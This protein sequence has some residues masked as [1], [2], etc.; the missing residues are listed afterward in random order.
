MGR[1]VGQILAHLYLWD[2]DCSLDQ[3]GEDL[4]LSKAAVSVAARQLENMGLVRRVWKKGDRRTYYR[5]A[6]NL[7]DAMRQGLLIFLGQKIQA[8]ASELDSAVESLGREIEYAPD[9][10]TVQFVF[11]RVKRAKTLRDKAM[12]L[13]DSPIVRLLAKV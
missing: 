10:K 8:V 11:G 9:D 7:A 12:Q 13:L 1:I 6:D 4:G 5:T 2:G 3:I